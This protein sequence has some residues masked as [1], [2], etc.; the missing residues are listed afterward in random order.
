MRYIEELTLNNVNWLRFGE[1]YEDWADFLD[2]LEQDLFINVSSGEFGCEVAPWMIHTSWTFETSSREMLRSLPEDV[3]DGE[4]RD[5]RTNEALV[6]TYSEAAAALSQGAER[7]REERDLAQRRLA[8]G[9]EVLEAARTL[10]PGS[11]QDP[12]MAAIL[13]SLA[14]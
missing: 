2:A 1:G 12:L 10:A 5:A 11:S 3:L 7:L 9:L 4:R 8:D 14:R 6:E 13:G